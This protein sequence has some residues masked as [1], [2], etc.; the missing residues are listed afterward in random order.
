[1]CWPGGSV[2]GYHDRKQSRVVQRT[3][4]I[5][6][7]PMKHH[8]GVHSMCLRHP[9]PH[10]HQAP[11]SAPQ[12]NASPQQNGADVP[13]ASTT[14]HLPSA[15]R[16]RESRPAPDGNFTRLLFSKNGK[17]AHVANIYIDACHRRRGLADE[18]MTTAL[19]WARTQE[20]NEMT[21]SA[22]EQAKPLYRRLGFTHDEARSALKLY[23]NAST[24]YSFLLCLT[25]LTNPARRGPNRQTSMSGVCR[26][27]SR[28]GRRRSWA[29]ASL[30]PRTLLV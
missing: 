19:R 6:T 7:P 17:S 25:V 2:F 29:L 9:Q 8:V 16:R 12:S 28:R 3:L 10:L 26:D 15:H 5:L 27:S 24:N 1:M 22:S 11:W 21:L 14:R 18:L 23:T 20:V 13:D 4:L 30:P